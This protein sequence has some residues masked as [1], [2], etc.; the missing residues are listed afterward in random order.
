MSP[1]EQRLGAV[2]V[3]DRAAVHLDATRKAIRVG[4]LALIRPVM[5]LTLGRWVA[6]M[7]WMPTARAFWASSPSGVSTSPCPHHQVGELVDDQ[8]EVGHGLE[9]RPR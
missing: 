8:D 3:E 2:L 6:R 4:K 1:P 7:R 5:T 9:L